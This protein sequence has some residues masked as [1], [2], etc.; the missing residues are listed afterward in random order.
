[1]TDY[2]REILAE[3]REVFHRPYSVFK[4]KEGLND[5]GLTWNPDFYVVKDNDIIMVI[6]V[7]REDTTLENLDARLRDAYAVMVLNWEISRHGGI[8]AKARALIV[9]DRVMNQ[10]EQEKYLKY[11]YVFEPFQCEIIGKSA[12]PELKIPRDE[13]D[14]SP[15]K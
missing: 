11:N 10:L 12:I 13:T 6:S 4:F 15:T 3:L 5:S 14:P 9:P 1:M 8:S 2:E 7:L